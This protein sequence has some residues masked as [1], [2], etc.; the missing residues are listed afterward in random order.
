MET[1][2]VCQAAEGFPV[3]F[4]RHAF[5]ADHVL[6]CDRVKPHTRFVG[7]IE[8]GLMKMMLIGLG[9]RAGAKVYHRAIQDYSFG[10]IVRSVAGEVLEKCRIAGR[11]GDRRERLR[12]DGA[13]RGR[14]SAGSSRAR[15]K[16]L[17]V[18]AKQWMPRLPFDHGRR[19]A[20]RPRS[21]RTSA[22]PGMD[23]NVVGRKFNDHKAVDGEL[24]KVKRICLRGLTRR[25]TATPSA[26]GSP[27]SA[28][29][30]CLR[31]SRRRQPRGSTRSSPAT[32]PAGMPPLDY[33]TDRE[34]LAAA[35]GT[36]GLVE[37]PERRGALDRRHAAPGRSGMLGAAYLDEARGRSDLE[38]LTEP[39]ALPFDAA[40]NLPAFA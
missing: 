40:G 32:S 12:R 18:L 20:D 27:S 11:A 31:D 37:P 29:R 22:A 19:A 38:I 14:R 23:T 5:E 1:V 26:S 4:D 25:R 24:P 7:D 16:E 9:K 28:G 10:Q 33:E 34:M 21:A 35:L 39:R 13:D 17:L 36:I 6:V 30:S 3:H 8:S 15:E 2:V